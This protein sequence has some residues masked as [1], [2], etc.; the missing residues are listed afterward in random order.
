MAFLSVL[1]PIVLIQ[2]MWDGKIVA[3]EYQ[4]PAYPP[5]TLGLNNVALLWEDMNEPFGTANVI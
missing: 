2:V 3:S 4:N 5:I 1:Q